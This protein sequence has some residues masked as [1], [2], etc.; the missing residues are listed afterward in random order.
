MWRLQRLRIGAIKEQSDDTLWAI[1]QAEGTPAQVTQQVERGVLVAAVTEMLEEKYE[2]TP[3]KKIEQKTAEALAKLER[4]Q[5]QQKNDGS[6]HEPPAK[7]VKEPESDPE[8]AEAAAT[9]AA[10]DNATT[11]ELLAERH[12]GHYSTHLHHGYSSGAAHP[13]KTWRRDDSAHGRCRG[14]YGSDTA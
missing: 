10:A 13:A 7:R 3:Q 8:A 6:R 1:A 4:I 11:Q 12:A 9:A 14:R 2:Y 5:K